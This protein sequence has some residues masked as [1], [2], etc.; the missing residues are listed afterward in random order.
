MR[1]SVPCPHS[2]LTNDGFCLKCGDEV[3]PML[4]KCCGAEI[5]ENGFCTDCYEHAA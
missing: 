3:D 5:D 1:A 4:S 2:V